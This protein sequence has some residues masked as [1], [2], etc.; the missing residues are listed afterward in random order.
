M[1]K[2]HVEKGIKTYRE[3]ICVPFRNVT[4]KVVWL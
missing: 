3:V 2:S 1:F 4:E